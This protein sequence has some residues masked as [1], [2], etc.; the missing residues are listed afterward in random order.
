MKRH[1]K[2]LF[3]LLSCSVVLSLLSSPSQAQR[4]TS[5][6]VKAAAR[7]KNHP[8]KN[9][10]R[11]YLGED[12]YKIAG[13]VWKVVS[14]ELDK[15][16]YPAWAPEMLRQKPGIV[17]GFHSVAEAEEA[18]YIASAYPM[19]NALLGLTAAEIIA[20]RKRIQTTMAARAGTRITLSDGVSTVLLPNGWTRTSMGSQS[21]NTQIGSFSYQGDLLSPSDGQSGIAFMF[22]TLPGNANVESFLS[23]DKVAQLKTQLRARAGADAQFAQAIAGAKVGTGKLGGL[24]GI[25]MIPGKGANLPAGMAGRMTIVGRGSKMYIMAAQ[26]P[27]TDKNYGLIV[28]SFQPR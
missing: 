5:P 3:L 11:H 23:P 25:T 8:P 16:Y 15:Y 7:L 24:S 22:L 10:I 4:V 26:L 20:A 9:W 2:S 13:G 6:S 28:N 27:T 17:I 1:S 19:D 21:Q 12:R 14:T 18:G